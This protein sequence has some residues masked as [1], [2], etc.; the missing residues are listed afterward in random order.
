MRDETEIVA[1]RCN[2][3][4]FMQQS[5]GDERPDDCPKCGGSDAMMDMTAGD[6]ALQNNALYAKP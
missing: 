4:M 3:C 6:I 2:H 5:A 1:T